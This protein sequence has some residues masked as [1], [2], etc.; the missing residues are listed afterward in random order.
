MSTVRASTP[1]AGKSRTQLRPQASAGA[2]PSV[3]SPPAHEHQSN[4]GGTLDG[5][6]G[7]KVG[8]DAGVRHPAGRRQG[9]RDKNWEH[10]E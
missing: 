9:E 6:R 3:C 8:E 7:G 2:I 1:R 10:G 5:D 4:G